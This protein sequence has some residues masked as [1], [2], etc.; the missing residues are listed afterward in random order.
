MSRKRTLSIDDGAPSPKRQRLDDEWISATEIR[1]VVMDNA[2]IAWLKQYGTQKGLLKDTKPPDTSLMEMGKTFEARVIE[3]I[4]AQF[5]GEHTTIGIDWK[6]ATSPEYALKTEEAIKK[7]IP[8]IFQAVLHNN[9][10]K[11]YG[12]ADLL[13][14]SDYINKLVDWPVMKAPEFLKGCHQHDKFHYCVIDIKFCTLPLTAD[15]IH[16]L[17]ESNT[18]FYKCQLWIYLEA[19]AEIQGY[20]PL[21]AYI[22]GRRWKSISKGIKSEGPHCFSKLGIIDYSKRDA[23]FIMQ[24][25]NAVLEQRDLKLNGRTWSIDPPSRSNLYPNMCVPSEYDAPWSQLKRDIA[26]RI[27][28]ITLVYQCGPRNRQLAQ[29]SGITKWSDDRCT[30]QVLGING[31]KMGPLVDSILATNR[32]P[33]T[34][35]HPEIIYNNQQDWQ[36]KEPLEFFIDFETANDLSLEDFSTLPH[37]QTGQ[38]IFLIGV[39]W[40][41]QFKHFIANDLSLAS[42]KQIILDF[43][44]FI[45]EMAKEYSMRASDIKLFHWGHIERTQFASAKERHTIDCPEYNWLDFCDIMRSEPITIKG[46][47][48]FGL[49]DVGRVMY[50]H[51]LIGT[52]WTSQTESGKEV[53]MVI[54]KCNEDAK[55][56]GIPLKD[57]ALMK[58]IIHYNYQ[59][60]RITSEIVE[61]FREYHTEELYSLNNI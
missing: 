49:K 51:G 55:N 15:S 4:K 14:R 61:Y 52:H 16:L 25:H 42:E 60:C 48:N 21:R 30:A 22:L 50:N 13:I 17:N 56:A 33:T 43:V 24:T 23:P 18:K 10:T 40:A 31:E 2:S 19:L 58:D 11:T 37:P 29:D 7:G 26:Q 59:D 9:Q 3:M 53:L 12:M 54:K 28:E 44:N 46:L 27:D 39:Y 8:I 47:F 5:V 34:I 45:D 38:R 57:H 32:D 36:I 35:V 6:E 1:H 20:N 41:T